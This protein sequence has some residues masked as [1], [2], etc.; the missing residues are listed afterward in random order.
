MIKSRKV[1]SAKSREHIGAWSTIMT[2]SLYACDDGDRDH[3]CELTRPPMTAEGAN[4][5]GEKEQE[6]K[7]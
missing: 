6:A 5:E 1:T 2:S 4:Y 7:Y 3:T